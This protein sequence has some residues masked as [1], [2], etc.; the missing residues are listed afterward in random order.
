MSEELPV[1]SGPDVHSQA[2]PIGQ[3]RSRTLPITTFKDR[4]AWIKHMLAVDCAMLSHGAKVVASRIALHHN[5]ETGQCNPSMAMLVAG[6]GMSDRTVRRML[7]ELE[8]AAWISVDRSRGYH[9]N[10]FDL[11][12]PETLATD[13]G[14]QE[15]QTPAPVAR[16]R[17]TN[18]LATSASNPSNSCKQ[19]LATVGRQKSESRTANRTAKD[20]DSPRLGE[21]DSG[22]RSQSHDHTDSDFELFYRQYPRKVSK[23]AALKI[24]RRIV[25]KGEATPADL[26]AGAMRYAAERSGQDPK[27]TKHPATWLNSGCWADEQTAPITATI[28][29]NGNTVAAPPP[30]RPPPQWGRESNTQRLMRKMRQHGGA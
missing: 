9:A 25:T 6:T 18:T 5:I 7:A 26:L 13:A 14:V 12:V 27:Y 28:D 4:D 17:N 30:N 19:T 8:Q 16:V 15:D 11:R 2:A 24:Y 10:S 20:I 3:C 29:S 21:E 23:V 22:R 1:T